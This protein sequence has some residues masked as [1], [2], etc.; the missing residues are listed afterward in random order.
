MHRSGVSSAPCCYRKASRATHVGPVPLTQENTTCS[1]S[2]CTQI[3]AQIPRQI[4]PPHKKTQHS[5]VSPPEQKP[6]TIIYALSYVLRPT[7][8][9]PPTP[10][11]GLRLP[12]PLP[13]PPTPHPPKVRRASPALPLVQA[14]QVDLLLLLLLSGRAGAPVGR[15]AATGTGTVERGRGVSGR[16]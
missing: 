1:E 7:P 15:A 4:P 2:N 16:G 8:H 6:N 14:G 11:R 9:M 12:P 3:P 13:W 5:L 10:P